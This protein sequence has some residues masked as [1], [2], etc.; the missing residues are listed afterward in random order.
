M[1]DIPVA[2]YCP[3]CHA[4]TDNPAATALDG[5]GRWQRLV[6]MAA[7]KYHPEC[8]REA[9]AAQPAVAPPNRDG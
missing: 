6:N 9:R 5:E 4:M 7:P 8:A 2:F 3:W 1:S